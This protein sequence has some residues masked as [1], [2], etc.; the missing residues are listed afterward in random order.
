MNKELCLLEKGNLQLMS[1][2]AD[3]PSIKTSLGNALSGC[4]TWTPSNW[5]DD[6]LSLHN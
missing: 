1:A 4:L 5:I 3:L 6:D 2:V